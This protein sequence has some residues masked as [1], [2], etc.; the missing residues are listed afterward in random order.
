MYSPPLY[1]GQSHYDSL[2]IHLRK[3][4]IEIPLLSMQILGII[5]TIHIMGYDIRTCTIRGQSV[6]I[7]C[8]H[9]Y[10]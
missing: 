9:L 2:R 1:N 4:V 3:H 10:L 5:N 6:G 7:L 8:R